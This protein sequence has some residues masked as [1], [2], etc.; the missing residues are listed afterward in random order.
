MD[1]SFPKP[2]EIPITGELDLHTFAPR[3]VKGV[4]EAYLEACRERGILQV[5][6]IHGK[7]TGALR[8]TVH[9]L[10]AKHPHVASYAL[11]GEGLGEWGATIANLKP[12]TAPPSGA[13]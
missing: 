11:G 8:N 2:V 13:R 1:E 3:D 10:L 6:I 5:R 4:V 12:I 7:G 9:A